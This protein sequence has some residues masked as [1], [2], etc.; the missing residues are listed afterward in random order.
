M[1]KEHRRQSDT[2]WSREPPKFDGSSVPTPPSVQLSAD[3][4]EDFVRWV[5]AVPISKAQLIRDEIAA[6][7]SDE[8]IF[9]ALVAS[10]L[11]LPVADF[12][13]HQLLLSI[14]GE[15]RNPKSVEPLIRFI[16]TPSDQV[17][18][19]PPPEQSK[20]V[21]TSYLDYSAALQARAVEMLAFIRTAEAL[22]AVLQAASGHISRAVRLAALDAFIFNHGDSPESIE[23]ARA[24]AR[25]EEA[26]FVG[27]P[28]RERGFN[29]AD[30]DAKVVAF[31]QRYP[32]EK[33]PTPEHIHA[34]PPRER[35][36][37]EVDDG[38]DS[39][40]SVRGNENVH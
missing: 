1:E 36:R 10:L 12:G 11:R 34:G 9:D 4:V 38:S 17:I 22:A 35:R 16:N 6:V 18:P 40:A 32:E 14:L 8:K 13:R 30:F 24:A 7:R 2:P 3:T 23:K 33:P 20:G 29:P 25:L 37:H 31:Y 27:L 19:P 21:N 5:A 39:A 26:K 15:L 28:R